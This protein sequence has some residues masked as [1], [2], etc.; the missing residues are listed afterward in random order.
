M[1]CNIS[2]GPLYLDATSKQHISA[3]HILRHGETLIQTV[4]MQVPCNEYT[5]RHF[6]VP[7]SHVIFL[8]HTFAFYDFNRRYQN[9][10]YTYRILP[11]EDKQLSVQVG[12][13]FDVII[14]LI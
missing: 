3:A 9:C 1:H 14:T 2:P 5:S 4:L 8:L 12:S 13:Q 6:P 7:H 11:N 10:V